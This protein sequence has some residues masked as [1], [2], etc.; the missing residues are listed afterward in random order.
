MELCCQIQSES[1]SPCLPAARRRSEA[2]VR[3]FLELSLITDGIPHDDGSNKDLKVMSQNAVGAEKLLRSPAGEA[4]A[5]AS[6]DLTELNQPSGSRR[7]ALRH[8]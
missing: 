6:P 1:P 2:N 4:L 5:T 8:H 3:L 7:L